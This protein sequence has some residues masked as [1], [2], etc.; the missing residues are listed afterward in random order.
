MTFFKS[1]PKTLKKFQKSIEKIFSNIYTITVTLKERRKGRPKMIDFHTHILPNIDN[2]S[3]NIE[4]TFNLIKEAKEA[5]F[6][7]IVLTS[8][9][10]EGYY[11][12]DTPE[13]EV[14]VNAITENLR[15]KGIDIKVY[16]ANEIYIT[17]NMMELLEAGKASTINNT[18]YVL[19][20]LPLDEEPMNLYQVIYS[21]QENKLIPVIA[22]PERYEF[23]QKEPEFVYELIEKGCYMQA[24]YGSILGQYGRKSQLIVKKLLENHSIHFLG[25]DVHRQGTIYP[26]MSEA[27]LEIENIIGKDKLKE[28]TTINPKLALGNK[29]I[30]IDTPYESKLSFKEKI[31]M[32]IKSY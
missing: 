31:K 12:T 1:G 5:G 32:Y 8:H 29:R 20:D 11:E 26:K 25:S 15:A 17:D 9:Y 24:N 21:L 14:W 18:C 22:H 27:L 23:I 16:L 3:R 13:R 6:E 19:I 10:K 7:G 4:E 30:D 2:G 28:L